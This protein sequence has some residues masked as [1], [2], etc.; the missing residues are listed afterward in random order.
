MNEVKY[1]ETHEWYI[2]KDG[3]VTVGISEYAQGEL[4]DIV[5]VTLPE[6]NTKFTKGSAVIELEA[7]KTIAEVYAPFDCEVIEIN[8]ALHSEPEL[9]NSDP[10]GAGWMF[11]AST[12]NYSDNGMTESEYLD[13]IS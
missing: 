9:I 5:F 4:G 2:E 12:D 11:K 3:I 1:L 8:E 10:L 6:I 13:F 7:T